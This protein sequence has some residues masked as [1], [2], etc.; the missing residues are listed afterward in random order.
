MRFDWFPKYLENA[1]VAS[2][3]CLAR[4]EI[5]PLNQSLELV[6]FSAP[7]PFLFAR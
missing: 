6:I 1:G 5:I 2:V 4:A 7:F 3:S